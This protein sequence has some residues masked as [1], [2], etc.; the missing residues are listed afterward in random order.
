MYP[1]DADLFPVPHC[2]KLKQAEPQFLQL[3]KL[4]YNPLI[5][6]KLHNV[7][8]KI[9]CIAF[10]STLAHKCMLQH[11]QEKAKSETP[12]TRFYRIHCAL[13]TS[14]FGNSLRRWWALQLTQPSVLN[15]SG[16]HQTFLLDIAEQTSW[17]SIISSVLEQIKHRPCI[18]FTPM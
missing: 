16:V 17:C 12:F 11:C 18:I 7:E 10:S 1:I 8:I 5:T 3:P 15:A 14:S 4:S 13:K 6:V 9:L 2:F